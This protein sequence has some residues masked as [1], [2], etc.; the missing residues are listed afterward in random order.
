MSSQQQR[1]YKRDLPLRA[2]Y[3]MS[4][5]SI[6]EKKSDVSTGSHHIRRKILTCHDY[7]DSI[8]RKICHDCSCFLDPGGCC[9]KEYPSKTQILQNRICPYFISHQP[10]HFEILHRAWQLYPR[11]LCKISK[12]Q[13]NCKRCY[14]W[15][16]FNR[17]II[18]LR[19]FRDIL[20]C[21][22]PLVLVW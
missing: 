22:W 13:W 16:N 7:I 17:W 1:W 5:V 18:F 11:A 3:G 14:R 6:L 21:N 2:S 19:D 12:W 9:T 10:N 15:R 4:V 8:R 20:Y